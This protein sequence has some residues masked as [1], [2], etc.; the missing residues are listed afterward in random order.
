MDVD[1]PYKFSITKNIT[2]STKI[3]IATI[4]IIKA[5][6]TKPYYYQGYSIKN[7]VKKETSING[8]K[9]LEIL[10]LTNASSM[11]FGCSGLTSLD[12]SSFDT[13]SVTS[14]S[15]MFYKCTSIT[16]II[17]PN[18]FDCSNV[19]NINTMFYRY[20]NLRSPLHLKNVKSTLIES[21]SSP[22]DWVVKNISGTRGVHYIVDSII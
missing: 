22:S 14:M 8:G 21:G 7:N 12:L 17:C 15:S 18:G 5:Y 1:N 16:S 9:Q 20:T 6:G 11:F 2:I 19:T 10:T 13:S 4:S 3:K